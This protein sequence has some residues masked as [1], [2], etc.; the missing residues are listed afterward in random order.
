MFTKLT[1]LVSA[2]AVVAMISST[3]QAEHHNARYRQLDDVAFAAYVEAREL[4]WELHDD[5]V[6]SRDYDHLLEDSEIVLIALQG[7]QNSI[8]RERSDAQIEREVVNVS[9]KLSDLTTHLNGCDFARVSRSRHRYSFNGRGY[10][11]TPETQHVGRVHVDVALKMIAKIESL[12]EGL[13]HEVGH[14]HRHHRSRS[15]QEV[16][17][18]PQPVL[19]P[20]DVRYRSG[21]GFGIPIGKDGNLV[22]NFGF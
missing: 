18:A 3:A 5:F 22:F 17:P 4:R 11:F 1:T 16:A 20:R 10:T 12:L 14:G 8:L 19:V 7:L 21:K 9:R 13:A 2:I 15:P 6:D